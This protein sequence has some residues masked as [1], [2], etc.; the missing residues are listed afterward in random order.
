MWLGQNWTCEWLRLEPALSGVDL[1]PY[2]FFSRDILVAPLGGDTSRMSPLA[3][4]I[5]TGLSSESQTMQK[6]ALGKARYLSIGDAVAVFETLSQRAQQEEEFGTD[7]QALQRL[8]DWAD[9]RSELRGELV[10]M[11][12]RLPESS[13]STVIIPKLLN[14][15][16]NHESESAARELLDKWS[17][18][19]ANKMLADTAR[20]RLN[21]VKSQ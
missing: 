12:R 10:L 19:T 15:C 5:F 4:E 8:F 16:K 2:F 14:L 13:I 7:N 3:Q 11:L 18:S 6:T 17:N 9:S 20:S 1:R 21:Q